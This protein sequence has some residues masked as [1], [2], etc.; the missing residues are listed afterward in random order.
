MAIELEEFYVIR[1][2]HHEV[3]KQQEAFIGPDNKLLR[4][5]R[6]LR[7]DSAEAAESFLAGYEQNPVYDY[8]IQFCIIEGKETLDT[9]LQKLVAHI[10]DI[11]Q[12][13]RRTAYNWVRGKDVRKILLRDSEEVYERHR[14]TLLEYD[15]D[16]T[17][18]SDIIL[19]RPSSRFDIN[20]VMK[21]PEDAPAQYFAYPGQR[22]KN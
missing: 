8:T 5:N 11:P 6:A 12:P 21:Q 18:P 16:I 22:P 10:M 17:R 3:T 2:A 14:H 20:D 13:Y 7:F 9:P 4:A 1:V 15:I 19:F